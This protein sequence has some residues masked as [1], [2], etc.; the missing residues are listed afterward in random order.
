MLAPKTMCLTYQHTWPPMEQQSWH[1]S[2]VSPFLLPAAITLCQL[3]LPWIDAD[4]T[5]Y[6]APAF[7]FSTC[8]SAILEPC[9]AHEQPAMQSS[10]SYCRPWSWDLPANS[11]A[12]GTEPDL[13][14][15]TALDNATAASLWNSTAV[16]QRNNGIYLIS[17]AVTSDTRY[18]ASRFN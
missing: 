9:S 6:K 12:V 11:S 8:H 14:G 15:S 16:P 7:M 17:P 18:V 4:M 5:S 2:M 1:S 13:P 10:A 3:N